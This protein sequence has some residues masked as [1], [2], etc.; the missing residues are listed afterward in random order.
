[1]LVKI[2]SILLTSNSADLCC[3]SFLFTT[4][5]FKFS[6]RKYLFKQELELLNQ[7][8]WNRSLIGSQTSRNGVRIRAGMDWIK[9]GNKAD[10]L[11]FFIGYGADSDI[12][13]LEN[14]RGARFEYF[15]KENFV[16]EFPNGDFSKI[17]EIFILI[18]KFDCKQDPEWSQILII[19]EFKSN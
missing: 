16:N 8:N 13:F 7:T 14:R 6:Y 18:L 2:I 10:I 19:F 5:A 1:M 3:A 11:L 12:D 15:E 9:I 4:E 17:S